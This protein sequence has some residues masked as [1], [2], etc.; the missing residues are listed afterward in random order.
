MKTS[1]FFFGAMLAVACTA[2]FVSCEKDDKVDNP[3]D[4][5]NGNNN[6]N[7][8]NDNNTTGAFWVETFGTG[9]TQTYGTSHKYWPYLEQYDGYDHPECQYSGWSVSVRNPKGDNNYVWIPASKADTV[10]MAGLPVGTKVSFKL[11]NGGKTA[12]QSD[13]LKVFCNDTEIT[14][15]GVELATQYEF[16]DFSA[17]ISVTDKWTLKF[18]KDAAD[19]AQIE[20]DDVAIYK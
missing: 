3:F 5:N 4:K 16:K 20:L 7:N 15:A 2:V 13:V 10:V 19:R 12:C 1:K 18:I 17:A 11:A 8:N 6:D 14:P 9:A